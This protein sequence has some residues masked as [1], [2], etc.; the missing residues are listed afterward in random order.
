M[1]Q[2]KTK[3]ENGMLQEVTVL[4]IMSWGDGAVP[5]VVWADENGE[6][7]HGNLAFFAS[8]YTYMDGEQTGEWYV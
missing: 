3:D 4:S 5:L 1:A 6:F 7:R 2:S 8:K